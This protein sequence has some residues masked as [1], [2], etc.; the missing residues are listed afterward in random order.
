MRNAAGSA[1]RVHLLNVSIG[2]ALVYGAD[3]PEVGQ[4]IR[5][6]CGISL[7]EARVAWKA[8]RRFGVTFARPIAPAQIEAI[9]RIQDEAIESATERLG[10]R[11]MKIVV[12]A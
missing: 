9:V 7:G 10:L 12:P 4:E 6:A 11:Q 1:A 5:L 3:A 2:G 8:G